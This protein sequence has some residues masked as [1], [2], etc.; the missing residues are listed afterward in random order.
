MRT[1]RRNFD[2]VAITAVCHDL[3]LIAPATLSG[4]TTLNSRWTILGVLFFSRAAMG[5][6]Y[7]SIGSTAH[8][9]QE[10]L[11]FN[12]GQVGTLIG[13]YF[14]TGIVLA[15][16]GGA[17]GAK[18][19]SK[20]IVLVGLAFMAVGSALAAYLSSWPGQAIARILAGTGGVLVNVLM[21]K[22]VSDWF[23]GKEIATAMGI[24]V[25]SWP[26]GIALALIA[27]PPISSAYG[28]G[29]AQV[30]AAIWAAIGF[31]LV[32]AAYSSPKE[33]AVASSQP[34]PPFSN[35][36]DRRTLLLVLLAGMVWG[37]FN[38]A[39]AMVFS[40][41]PANLM[42]LGFGAA[43]AGVAVS[44]VM[45]GSMISVP[46]GGL[47]ADRTGRPALTIVLSASAA[48]VLIIVTSG[49]F[50]SYAIFP[51]LGFV[52]GLAAGPIMALPAQTLAPG[53]RAIGMGVF[54]TIFYAV[55]VFAPI[56]AGKLAARAG[57]A[58]A[59]YIIGAAFMALGLICFGLFLTLRA[60]QFA[61][62][63]Q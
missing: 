57:T 52:I 1:N 59:G 10:Q 5:F 27:I 48:L 17:L 37:W 28:L 60:R 15:I 47:V 21:A 40:F 46:L 16:P 20:N 50:A 19:G 6:Q 12:F 44:F 3:Y 61:S 53:Q 4:G 54:F 13:I 31:V 36:L 32:A 39:F 43:A 42:E 45:W 35:Q 9:L 30:A 51:L 2:L 63:A 18:F 41:G 34:Q 22:M 56:V 49:A 62:K 24:F 33:V 8:A 38:A 7:Q 23:A 29:G 26:V 55:M 58:Q 11:G 14:V 25:N